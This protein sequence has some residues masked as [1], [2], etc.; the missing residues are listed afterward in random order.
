MFSSA[1]GSIGTI[2]ATESWRRSAGLEQQILGVHLE[3]ATRLESLQTESLDAV[4]LLGPPYHLR[5]EV[6]TKRAVAEAA[7]Y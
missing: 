4:L 1:C 7:R 5:S 3:L 2:A 6:E